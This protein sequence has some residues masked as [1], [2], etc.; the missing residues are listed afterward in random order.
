MEFFT[1]SWKGLE[2]NVPGL[3]ISICLNLKE[4]LDRLPEAEVVVV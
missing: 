1:N 2:K 3:N 4:F